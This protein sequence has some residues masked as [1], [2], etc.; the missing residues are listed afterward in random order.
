MPCIR[1]VAVA[2]V[3]MMAAPFAAPAQT[4][5]S[6]ISNGL[7][8]MVGHGP[9]WDDATIVGG[10]VMTGFSA[11]INNFEAPNPRVFS[12]TVE[13]HLF[14]Q[15]GNRPDGAL[16]G[17]FPITSGTAIN[18]GETRLVV[19][20]GLAARG[21][22]LPAD[23]RLGVLFTFD[24]V[25]FAVLLSNPPTVGASEDIYWRD[26]P[27]VRGLAYPTVVENLSFEIRVP[28]PGAAVILTLGA[29]AA[30]GPGRQ[31]RRAAA[32]VKRLP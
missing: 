8:G 7:Q 22:L 23:A 17:S 26:V 12:G 2:A 15:A 30:V 19:H 18:P 25:N 31:R 21:I 14:D 29:A 27:P 13:I 20:D 6:N 4:V 3:L 5:Y 9:V 1:P 16:L 24:Q 11:R 28:G 10:G 32:C